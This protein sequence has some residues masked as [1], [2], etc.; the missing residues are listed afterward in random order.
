MTQLD[1]YATT[2]LQQWLRARADLVGP[3]TNLLL[4]QLNEFGSQ[5]HRE[6]FESI[7]RKK[8]DLAWQGTPA[9]ELV[10]SIA[11]LI[12]R[13]I[14]ARERTIA[15][16]SLQETF[17]LC[18]ETDPRLSPSQVGQR[19]ETY[20]ELSGSKGLIRQF[21]SVHLCNVILIDLHDSL[22]V[23]GLEMFQG[24]M[25]GIERLCQT[26]AGLAVRSW[27]KWPKLTST[28]ITSATQIAGEAMRKAIDPKAHTARP[29]V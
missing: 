1:S 17:F 14:S 11:N 3:K 8:I 10:E 22:Q 15:M 5:V 20:L 6:G 7:L 21:L 28:T 27:E 26:A 4:Q 9:I 12:C 24:R 25:E 23:A 2:K 19:L 13:G 29:K 16:K 18:T